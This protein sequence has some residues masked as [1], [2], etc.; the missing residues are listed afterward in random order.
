M[1]P[2]ATLETPRLLLRPY[3]ADDAPDVALACSDELTQ[4][5][6]PLPT[7][8]TEAEGLAWCTEQAPGIRASGDGV[9]WAAVPRSGGR[10]VGSFGLTRTDWRA[11]TSE[12]GYWV[13]PWA[14]RQGVAVEGVTAVARWLLEEHEFE[15]LE[16]RAAV[17]N[18]PS[19]RVAERAGFL[20]EGLARNA[21]YVHD[22]RVDLAVFSLVRSDLGL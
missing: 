18:V 5:W 9:Q 4:R 7:P 13:A 2:E 3:R 11:R 19:Q 8:Y 1:F 12:I 15:R 16:L 21:G 14:R 10:L 20:R 6:L 17:G 22:G